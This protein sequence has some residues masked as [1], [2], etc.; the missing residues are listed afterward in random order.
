MTDPQL[1]EFV[2][3]FGTII[4]IILGLYKIKGWIRAENDS[5]VVVVV[6]DE[7]AKSEE[8]RKQRVED[9]VSL[10]M[11]PA[12]EA[13]RQNCKSDFSRIHDRLDHL[14]TTVKENSPNGELKEIIR[15]QQR[16]EMKIDQMESR[17]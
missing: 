17:I 7:L 4:A 1:V 13:Q 3:F 11:K 9:I 16:L 6:K 5:R 2:K 14:M 8:S 10:S 12:C 15:N